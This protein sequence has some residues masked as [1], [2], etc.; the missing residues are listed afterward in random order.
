MRSRLRTRWIEP[1]SRKSMPK[2]RRIAVSSRVLG[3]KARQRVGGDDEHPAEAGQR[4]GDLLGEAGRQMRILLG[5]ADELQRHDA[6]MGAAA[7]RSESPASAAPGSAAVRRAPSAAGSGGGRRRRSQ[8][9]AAAR[10]AADFRQQLLRLG[11]G[12]GVQQVGQHG[13]AAVIGLDRHAALAARGMR[14]HQ[15]PPGT[16]V[17]PVDLQQALRR[18]DRRLRLH[19]LA[20][21]RLGHGAG[22]VAQPFALG[23]QP[24]VEGRIDAV[25]VLQQ[26][27]V[28]QRQRRRLVGGRPHHL[29]HV[30]PDHAR[31]KRQV[32]AGHRQNLG[33]GRRQ[34]LR[35]AD[36]FPGAARRG[37]APR[38]GG[39]TAVRPAGRAGRDAAMTARSRRAARGSCVRPAA[40]SRW[41]ASR[42]PSGRSAAAGPRPARPCSA[43]SCGPRVG[44][45]CQPSLR[46][47][48]DA[49][50]SRPGFSA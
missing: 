4:R 9:H 47:L 45:K 37:P 40:R 46:H 8:R 29:L 6:D 42:L 13:A 28:Q 39:S 34:V 1:S 24:G 38:G 21:Q 25:Q 20:Q 3:G 22:T 12:R 17:R 19:L 18:R 5:G 2:V 31:A 11:R 43:A 36:E 23:G 15:R 48:C 35:A 44:V 10:G 7:G 27:A 14:P 33:P 41:S 49:R 50:L 32:V 30:H 16:L 26:V